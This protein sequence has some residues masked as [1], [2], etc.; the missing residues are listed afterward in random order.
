MSGS[1]T[2]STGCA[3][4]EETFH[5]LGRRAGSVCNAQRY[6]PTEA[7]RDARAG[8]Y[9]RKLQTK[10]GRSNCGYALL[11]TASQVMI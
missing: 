5:A 3:G 10:A 1:K 7:R 9:E 4:Q 11:L 6:E 8:Q 2:T